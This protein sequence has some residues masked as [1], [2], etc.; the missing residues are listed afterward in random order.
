MG[1]STKYT[2]KLKFKTELSIPQLK[3]LESLLGKKVGDCYVDLE[4]TKDYDGL[5]WDGSEKSNDMD[6]QIN[7]IIKEM[8]KRFPEFGLIGSMKAQGEDF[9]DRYHII[10]NNTDG[11][12]IIKNTPLT[13]KV[14]T[15]PH[16]EEKFE[17]KD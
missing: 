17:L 12:A 5:Q 2:G 1:Y 8:R 15:C 4:I 14:V 6:E 16:C 3:V 10:I 7:A 13:G 9:D 11:M